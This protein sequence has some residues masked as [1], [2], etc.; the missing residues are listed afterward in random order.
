MKTI[1]PV[2][3]KVGGKVVPRPRKKQLDFG[4]N[5]I[6]DQDPRIF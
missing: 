1:W 3:T 4:G 5:L 2:F 6:P